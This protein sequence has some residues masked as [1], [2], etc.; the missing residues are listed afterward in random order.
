MFDL[1]L[2]SNGFALVTT[3]PLIFGAAGVTSRETASNLFCP[4]LLFMS[5]RLETEPRTSNV[6]SIPITRPSAW[7]TPLRYSPRYLLFRYS[8]TNQ[9]DRERM[10]TDWNMIT[11]LEADP[12]PVVGPVLTLE[13]NRSSLS[14]TSTKHRFS[15][16]MNETGDK[17]PQYLFFL[18][19]K[20]Q[21]R[22]ADAR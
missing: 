5:I 16:K 13:S 12:C 18:G 10:T 7:K 1:V 17:N 19:T 4:C 11:I 21:A 14:T 2:A 20:P 3:T 9:N 15:V 6:P 22:I 8:S